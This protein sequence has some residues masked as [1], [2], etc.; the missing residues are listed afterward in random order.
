MGRQRHSLQFTMPQYIILGGLS[1]SGKSTVARAI[2]DLLLAENGDTTIEWLRTD[3]IRKDLAKV[4]HGTTLPPSSYTKESSQQVYAEL[5]KKARASKAAMV[6]VDG[7]F[8][9]EAER[10]QVMTLGTD[11]K[12]AIG[13]WLHVDPAT[14]RQRLGNRRGDVSDASVAVYEQQRAQLA[15][16]DITWP[17]VN[18]GNAPNVVARQILGLVRR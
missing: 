13:V 15:R 6:L 8:L 18:T 10:Q 3:E 11:T 17:V 5:F 1:G 12:P 16:E 14:V 4:S 7:V 9:Q 2:R